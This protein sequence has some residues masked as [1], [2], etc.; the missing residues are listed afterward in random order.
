[1]DRQKRGESWQWQWL[2]P[3]YDSGMW[4]DNEKTSGNR[5]GKYFTNSDHISS[6]FLILITQLLSGSKGLS[7]KWN[8]MG[9][10]ERLII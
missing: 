7:V 5:R 10:S 4:F 9:T 6:S 3:T 1:M 8:L 2:P